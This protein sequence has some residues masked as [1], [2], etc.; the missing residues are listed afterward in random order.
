MPESAGEPR[1]ATPV[2][3]SYDR[4]MAPQV[5]PGGSSPRII[6]SSHLDFDWVLVPAAGLVLV[7]RTLDSAGARPGG[8]ALAAVRHRG[9]AEVGDGV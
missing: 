2:A 3:R 5:G 9:T 6:H 4:A 1:P 8:C 7:A